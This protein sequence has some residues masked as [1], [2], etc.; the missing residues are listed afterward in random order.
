MTKYIYK[1]YFFKKRRRNKKVVITRKEEEV[2]GI[3]K[4]FLF[5]N[6]WE[7]ELRDRDTTKEKQRRK[8]SRTK[9]RNPQFLFSFFLFSLFFIIHS[10]ISYTHN[11]RREEKSS[12][13][14]KNTIYLATY[15]FFLGFL[16]CFPFHMPSV[17]P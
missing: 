6:S 3:L 10:Q 13:R 5:E 2:R 16:P 1:K 12:K 4:S 9:R 8:L 7:R 14:L 11:K 17:S 15:T